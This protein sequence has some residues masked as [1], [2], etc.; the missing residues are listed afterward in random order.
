MLRTFALFSYALL[1]S[2][3]KKDMPF[4]HP[5]F[6]IRLILHKFS[7]FFMVHP[8][9]LF[10]IKVIMKLSISQRSLSSYSIHLFI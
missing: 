5:N 9:S 1:Y 7:A 8:S 6:S 10:I 2:I 4:T 3:Q